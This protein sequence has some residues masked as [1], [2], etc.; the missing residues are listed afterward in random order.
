MVR[1][2]MNKKENLLIIDP[3]PTSIV[4]K[5]LYFLKDHYNITFISLSK[6]CDKSEF[7]KLGIETYVFNFQGQRYLRDKKIIQG[8]KETFKFLKKIREIKKGRFDVVLA[9]TEPNLVGYFLFKIFKGSKKVYFPYDISLFR[10]GQNT[11][12]RSKLDIFAEKYCFQ[13]AD[14]IIHKGP[15]NEL[16]LIKK[17]EINNILAKRINFLPYC[18]DQWLSKIN[19]PKDKLPN[20]NLVYIGGLDGNDPRYKLQWQDLFRI[21]TKDNGMYLHCYC[22]D[23]IEKINNKQIVMHKPLSNQELN[24]VMG[25]YQYGTNIFFHNKIVDNRWVKTSLSNKFFSFLE[26]GIPIIVNDELEFMAK[27][28]KKYHCGVV[29]SEKDFY[30]LKDI[31]SK[32]NYPKLLLGVKRARKEF[33]MNKHIPRLIKALNKK[34]NCPPLLLN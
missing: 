2:E 14:L 17:Y 34:I 8:L 12:K 18:F 15:E 27:L 19:K 26:A 9:R 10:F 21:M 24:K 16:N 13:K 31:L 33:L 29:V 30:N 5:L 11:K 6:R 7:E 32:Q 20:I 3:E 28:V 1:F 4:H 25:K 23:P 22:L